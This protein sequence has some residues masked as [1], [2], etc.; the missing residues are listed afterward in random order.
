MIIRVSMSRSFTKSIVAW[1]LPI[2][3]DIAT[4]VVTVCTFRITGLTV[5]KLAPVTT[6]ATVVVVSGKE[7]VLGASAGEAY[8]SH[9]VAGIPRVARR[10]QT[11]PI[12]AHPIPVTGLGA[13]LDCTCPAK[14]S[15]TG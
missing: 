5:P 1:Q 13:P 11:L 10:A 7:N 8:R 3:A 12:Q 9:L 4:L 14:R 2:Y 6:K 15:R